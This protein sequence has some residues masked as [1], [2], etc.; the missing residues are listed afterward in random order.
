MH[1]IRFQYL[2]DNFYSRISDLSKS[3]SSIPDAD[4]DSLNDEPEIELEEALGI[5]KALYPFEGIFY[6]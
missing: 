6:F 1:F 4:A 3:H 5:G 2:F